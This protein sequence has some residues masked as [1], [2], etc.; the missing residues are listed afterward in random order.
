MR[1][2]FL[3]QRQKTV[4]L[5]VAVLG[6]VSVCCSGKAGA[7]TYQDTVD[8][9]F[10][11]NPTISVSLSA[12]ISID[13]LTPGDS[14]D[15]NVV[16]VSVATNAG[17][18]YYL[19]ATAG[20][21]NLV[22]TE[23]SNYTFT[24]ITSNLASPA[25]F[26]DN[27]WGYAYS[28]NGGSTWVSGD[29]G[30]AVTGYNG[31]PI[32][33][34]GNADAGVKMVD[35]NAYA[36]TGSVQFKIGAKASAVQAAGTYNGTV[37]FYAVTYEPP[38]TMQE[39]AAGTTCASM[40]T[41]GTI[42]LVDNRDGTSY[43]VGKLA[44]GN[45]WMLDNLALDPTTVPLETLQGK[46]NASNAT[47]GYLK[48]GGGSGQYTATA[49]QAKTS[50]G[51]SW[52]NSYDAPYVATTDINTVP[53]NAPTNGAGSNKVGVYYNYCA[54]SAGSYCYAGDAGAGD[55]SED[56][57]PAGWRMPTGNTSGEFSAL[58]YQIYGSTGSTSNTTQV[59][60]Y[61]NAL[62]LPLSGSFYSGSAS[63][64]GSRG[65]WWSST[66]YDGDN[67]YLLSATT[68]SIYPADHG[69]RRNGFSLRCVLGS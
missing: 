18:G 15:S 45:C 59:N 48:N 20:A 69:N 9:E 32:D 39:F 62:S 30:S 56:L 55:A 65:Y 22:N 13:E 35:A 43:T 49:V 66:R 67:M 19:S 4:I 52:T 26:Q 68:S 10:T 25:N 1:H 12:P 11:V 47:L 51:G 17:Y 61:R 5:L 33:T 2:N 46:T 16:T 63:N 44:D 58:A 38:A 34:G 23:N 41:G 24:S 3:K 54:A 31:L 8:Q 64:K 53:D 6:M 57:C 60:N 27:E 29:V 42:S 21:A 14:A 36:T 7:V 50:D 28:T 37:N 40:S